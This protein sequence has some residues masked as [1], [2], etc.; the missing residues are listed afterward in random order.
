MV[1]F[2]SLNIF[3][4]IDF[5]CLTKNSNFCIP[6]TMKSVRYLSCE[7]ATQ[8]YSLH[9]LWFLVEH[10]TVWVFHWGNFGNLIL[11]V[12]R[13]S[14]ILI[15]EVWSH[16]FVTFPNYFCKMCIPC[17]MQSLKFST[18]SQLPT[19]DFVKCLAPKSG[20]RNMSTVT[21]NHWKPLHL[22]RVERKWQPTSLSAPQQSQ[23]TIHYHSI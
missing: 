22:V 23:I 12:F 4:T 17:C 19:K 14:W 16:L 5:T 7:W 8:F 3:K 2:S 10:W 11:L 13:D 15:I 6:A 1:S 21:L 18:V 9:V 20:G